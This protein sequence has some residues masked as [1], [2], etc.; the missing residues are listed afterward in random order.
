MRE[1]EDTLRKAW[2]A[3]Q[4]GDTQGAWSLYREVLAL[5]PWHAEANNLVGVLHLRA[6]EAVKAIRHI[7]RALKSSPNDARSH[8]NL[9]LALVDLGRMDEAAEAFERAADLDPGNVEY[10]ASHGNA[11]RL[12][13]RPKQAVNVLE[14]AFRKASG[15]EAIRLNLALAH[16]DLGAGENRAGNPA[17]AATHFARALELE[18]NLEHAHLNMGLTMEQAGRLEAAERHYRAAIESRP[19]FASAHFYLAHLRT[20]RSDPREIEAMR[21]LIRQPKTTLEDRVNLAYGLGIALESNGEF[22]EAFAFMQE[23]H[24]LQSRGTQFDLQAESDRFRQIRELFTPE[25]L[26]KSV[27]GIENPA[28]I[29]VC[30][31][32]RSGTTLTEQIL[33]S[34]RRVHG[35][36]EQTA[37]AAVANRLCGENRMPFPAGLENLPSGK[38]AEAARWYLARVAPAMTDGDMFTDT[39]PMNFLY[40]GLARI[41][42]PA[43]RFVVCLRDP[44]DNCLSLF[45]QKLTGGNDYAH[46]LE[47]LGGYYR[48]HRELVSHW[49][50]VL[51]D[52]LI[53]VQYESLVTDLE[54]QVRRLLAFC[55]LEFD[56]ACLRFHQSDRHVKS[57]SAA[58]VRQPLYA[59]SVGAWKSYEAQLAP[60]RSALGHWS[61]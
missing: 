54:P 53:T 38:V 56:P 29:F 55:G 43:A 11:M 10:A 39:T 21:K 23:A 5:D 6:G 60:L 22:N 20:H 27:G 30:G 47:D 42:F 15:S 51:G 24:R 34:H 19:D 44:M 12:S 46:S 13:G 3:Q 48:L 58:Q 36:G 16:N 61:K 52:R 18:P 57:P 41:L 17:G 59:S 2:Q 50:K 28:P 1:I 25:H 31:M 8:A 35:T 37:L 7:R 14:N 40:L 26:K 32:P 4:A 45:R 49:E 33:A 9:G